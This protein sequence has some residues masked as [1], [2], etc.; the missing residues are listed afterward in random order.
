MRRRDF[1]SKLAVGG[2]ATILLPQLEVVDVLG[3][4]KPVNMDA[5]VSQG[6]LM[7]KQY[8]SSV[9]ISGRELRTQN[10]IFPLLDAKIDDACRSMHELM[11]KQMYDHYR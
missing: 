10:D 9:A 1:L 5:D 2:T 6:L 11:T 3:P 8:S 4:Y 7:W